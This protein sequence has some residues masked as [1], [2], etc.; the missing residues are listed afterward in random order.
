MI[1]SWKDF[2]K[3][4]I[5][6][7]TGEA[8]AYGLRLLCDINEDGKK[9][10]EGFLG[11]IELK[12]PANM[13]SKVNGEPAIGSLVLPRAIFPDLALYC[14]FHVEGYY[15]AYKLDGGYQG[16]TEEAF[17]KVRKV[18]EGRIHN[19]GYNPDPKITRNGRNVHQMTGRVL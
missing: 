15:G 19:W 3:Y 16:F 6:P 9:L 7:L 1:H 12:P 2:E 5:N 18:F 11:L 13:N 10:L 14:L 4:G 17:E 8:C